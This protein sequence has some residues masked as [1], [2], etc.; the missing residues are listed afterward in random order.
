MAL[1]S[2][3]RYLFPL[4]YIDMHVCVSYE[5]MMHLYP[6]I[7]VSI[8][9]KIIHWPIYLYPSVHTNMYTNLNT[10]IYTKTRIT[11]RRDEQLRVLDSVI[12][13]IGYSQVVTTNNYNTLKITVNT[14]HKIRSS[15]H[16]LSL[17]RLTSNSS[18]TVLL[19]LM[20]SNYL[21][22]LSS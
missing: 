5:C 8:Y 17:R 14:T 16:M 20:N 9:G 6:S 15:N 3:W 13:F 18:P 10:S 1:L 21:D 4:P 2:A 22:A 11:G 12:G 19:K 7:Y